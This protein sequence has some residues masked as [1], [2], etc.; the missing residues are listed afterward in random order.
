MRSATTWTRFPTAKP[1]QKP[2][3]NQLADAANCF[4]DALAM[5]P[6]F[7]ELLGLLARREIT[8]AQRREY[9]ALVDGQAVALRVLREVTNG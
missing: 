3:H 6:R 1:T 4:F 5:S 9:D 2:T 8:P 7:S